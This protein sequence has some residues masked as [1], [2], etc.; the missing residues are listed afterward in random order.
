[1]LAQ[2]KRSVSGSYYDHCFPI[3][4]VASL[5][6]CVTTARFKV[7][8]GGKIGQLVGPQEK[9]KPYHAERLE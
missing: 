8:R 4:S 2:S 1:M 3:P 9:N 5:Y 7:R 6:S